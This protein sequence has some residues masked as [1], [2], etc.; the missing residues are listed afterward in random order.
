[1]ST[2]V[3]EKVEQAAGILQEKG[4]DLWLTFA[5]ETSASG[6]PVLPL[7]YGDADLTWQSA[8][9]L[10]RSGERFAIVGR[11]DAETARSLGAYPKVIAYDE[12]LRPDLL[13][14][15]ERLS[16][17]QIALNYSASDVLADGLSHGLYQV[18]MGY[19]QDTP[20]ADRI[21][22]AEEMIMALRGR[23]TPQEITRI[24]AAVETTRQI[25]ERTFDHIRP[26]MTEIEIGDFMEAQLEAFGV[27]PAWH[28]GHCPTVNA[29]PDSPVGHVGRGEYQVARGQLLHFDFGVKQDGYCS[30]IQRVVYFL[31]PGE[32]QPPQ[33]VRHGFETI[34]RAIQAT[35]A[36]MKP[37]MLGK[38]VD[39]VARE[40]VTGAGYAEYMY[41]T[42]HHLGRLAHDGGGVLAPEWERY[43]DGPNQ[44]LEA[45]HVYT[46][47]PGLAVPGYGYVGLEEDVVVTETGA[48]FL[49]A[50][51]VELFLR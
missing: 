13:R 29:G 3:Q 30:D 22:S 40:I 18:L 26:G 21:V 42:G 47:E 33:A 31:A 35:V 41:G 4:I 20:F 39:A 19:L 27:E 11:F 32:D 17:R 14:L 6:D 16:P 51:Q 10:T 9:L 37:G 36:A 44:P 2:I 38:E 45:G 25:Y 15:L 49:G 34:V 24:R 1:V 50:P 28:P 5:R 7:I 43:G 8:L 48:E 12:A 23:K 46:V